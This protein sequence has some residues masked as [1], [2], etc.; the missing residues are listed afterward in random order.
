MFQLLVG[1]VTYRLVRPYELAK[2][3]VTRLAASLERTPGK[4]HLAQNRLPLQNT[5]G[6]YRILNLVLLLPL[7]RHW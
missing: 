5:H 3:L 2:K 1:K 4:R 6:Q 7:G